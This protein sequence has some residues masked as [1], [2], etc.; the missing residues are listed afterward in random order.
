MKFNNAK[1]AIQK[2]SDLTGFSIK[3]A[4]QPI[5][6]RKLG[7][8]GLQV[9]IFS[10]GGQGAL[11]GQSDKKE[12]VKIIQRAYE[13]GVNY[14]DTSPVY[15]PSEDF[16][17]AAISEFRNNI[18]LGTK[19]DKRDR[20]NALKDLEESLNRLNTDYIDVWQIH[21]IKD[22]EEV[23]EIFSQN[24]AIQAFTEMKEQGVIKYIGITG[25]ECPLPLLE[26]MK[27]FDFDTVLCPI[28]PADVHVNPSFKKELLPTANQKNIGIIGMKIF[29]QGYIFH[30]E[31]I[32]TTWE[33]LFYA[34]SQPIS[35]V[36][37]GCDST[38]QL[39]E[40]ITLSKGFYQLD[41]KIL[42]EIE[43]KTEGVEERGAFFRKSFGGYGS[44]EKLDVLTIF[45]K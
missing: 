10:L 40:N 5:P 41:Q 29:S 30:P 39:E 24:G 23:D 42:Q 25:H 44:Q 9:G 31:G 3:I 11:E 2:L 19:S 34:M 43:K 22:N 17:G 36:I 33:P 16:Y 6:K 32:K 38:E 18:I 4:N 21:N 1:E 37:V 45:E 15:G 26:A 13:L 20:D 7:K 8:T 28:N 35:T 14:F 12:M 27:R